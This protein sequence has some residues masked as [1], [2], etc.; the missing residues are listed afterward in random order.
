MSN[1]P[2]TKV[3]NVATITGR[4]I[5]ELKKEKKMR[6]PRAESMEGSRQKGKGK[7]GWNALGKPNFNA[8]LVRKSSASARF[9]CLDNEAGHIYT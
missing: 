2:N 1:F 7:E 3:S 9:P 4:K 5:K 6:K 8:I